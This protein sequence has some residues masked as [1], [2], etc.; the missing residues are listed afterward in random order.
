MS[1]RTKQEL[2]DFLPKPTQTRLLELL[3]SLQTQLGDDLAG[4]LVYGGAVRGGPGDPDDLQLMVVL[5]EA[6]PE[7]LGAIAEALNLLRYAV[8]IEA[9]ILTSSEVPQAADVF[10]LLYDDIRSAHVLLAGTDPFSPLAISDRHRRLRIEQELREA[11]IRLR[12]LLVDSLGARA[13]LGAG[14]AR[15]LRQVRSPLRALLLLQKVSCSAH[16]DDVLR[17]AGER[18]GIDTAPLLTAALREAPERAVP[19]LIRL[20]ESAVQEADRLPD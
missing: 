18:Y 20:L 14:L 17:A 3:Q 4:L 12:R 9:M 5:R 13:A 10:P 6:S 15:K 2:L 16:Q 19:L 11:Q 7:K 1:I 8:R